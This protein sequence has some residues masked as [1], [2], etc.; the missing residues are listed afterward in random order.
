MQAN[1]DMP[2]HQLME[3]LGLALAAASFISLIIPNIMPDPNQYAWVIV[4][5]VALAPVGILMIGL[6]RQEESEPSK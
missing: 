1:H 3:R 5:L 2:K 6:S 4:G